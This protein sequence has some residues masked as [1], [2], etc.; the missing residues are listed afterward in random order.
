[1]ENRIWDTRERW[2]K[3]PVFTMIRRKGKNKKWITNTP[4]RKIR[5]RELKVGRFS[6][7]AF[8]EESRHSPRPG[9]EH[10]PEKLPFPPL[11][12]PA[13]SSLGMSCSKHTSAS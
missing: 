10:V 5:S 2:S 3:E 9:T 6:V 12:P 4:G 13:L 11:L 8:Q 7:Q 1:M